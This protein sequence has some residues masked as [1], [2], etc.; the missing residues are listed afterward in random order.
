[1]DKRK[2]QIIDLTKQVLGA[3]LAVESENKVLKTITINM[4]LHRSN[5]NSGLAE[6]KNLDLSGARAKDAYWA[7]CDFE[8]ADF[9]LADL[10][11]SSFRKSNLSGAQFREAMLNKA[12][13]DESVCRGTNFKMADL[14]GA[15]FKN[16]TLDG[17]NFEDA[18]VH[19][20]SLISANILNLID[21]NVDVSPNG[22]GSE[23]L[24]LSEWLD[25]VSRG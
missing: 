16:A 24:L 19:S 15:S 13:L 21:C 12:V 22:D 17:V 11:D 20:V 7:K 3:A 4:V 6:V 10:S 25:R 23:I 8:Y 5:T 2:N 1:M 14:R 9:Y 18:K